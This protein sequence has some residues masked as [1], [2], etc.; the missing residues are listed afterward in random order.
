VASKDVRVRIRH[1]PLPNS[2]EKPLPT[3][4]HGKPLRVI[5][6]DTRPPVHLT[7][8][9][10]EAVTWE[11]YSTALVQLTRATL[12][13]VLGPAGTAPSAELQV[14]IVEHEATFGS[15]RW[16]GAAALEATLVEDSQPVG[17]WTGR[18]RAE[19]VN[20]WGYSTAT[21][22]TQAAYEAAVVDVLQQM[23]TARAG[24]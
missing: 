9:G 3:V 16:I 21:T 13:H 8:V 23:P 5:V 7:I 18:G 4:R 11:A 22:A 19:K 24:R 14:R 15:G 6:T 20:W 12:Q 17:S 10:A 2:V 1:F